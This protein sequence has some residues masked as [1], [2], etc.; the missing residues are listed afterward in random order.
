M[1]SSSNNNIDIS[2][3]GPGVITTPSFPDGYKSASCIWKFQAPVNF[4]VAIT[5]EVLQLQKWEDH[6]V[7]RD[8]AD[9]SAP[10]I[11]KYGPC[12]KGSLTLF[13]STNAV[14][15]QA[16]FPDFSTSNDL[17]I[18]YKPLNSGEIECE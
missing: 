18:A 9:Q 17:R 4:V 3:D 8:G 7:I 13:S 15:L 11:G 12:A 16:N 14:F 5:I 6:L 2:V 1:C 10:L